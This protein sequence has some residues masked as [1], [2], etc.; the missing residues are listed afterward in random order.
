MRSEQVAARMALQIVVTVAQFH[1]PRARV[2]AERVTQCIEALGEPRSEWTR[3][4]SASRVLC[5][6]SLRT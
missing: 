1:H 2:L 3:L 6:N 5:V 4:I